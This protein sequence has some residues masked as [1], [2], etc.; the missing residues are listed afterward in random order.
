[1][2]AKRLIG[3]AALGA[4]VLG[5]WHVVRPW[6]QRW[7]ASDAELARWYPGDELLPPSGPAVTHAVTVDAP[8]ERIWPWLAQI[9]QHHGGFYS[10]TW[11]ENLFGCRMRNAERIVPEWQ[12]VRF[13]DPVWLHPQAPPM[14]VA[15][16]SANE[17]LV[18]AATFPPEAAPA[19]G[20]VY[21]IWG[22]HLAPLPGGRTRM[23][24]RQRSDPSRGMFGA[25][26]RLPETVVNSLFWEPAHFIME[27]R[28]LLHIKAL[29]EREPA[30]TAVETLPPRSQSPSSTRSA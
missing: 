15:V 20:S 2:N 23:I 28:M 21:A 11:L 8:P 30:S 13:N 9:G 17:A 3:P 1:M 6:H 24:A 4:A 10:Y 26:L 7:G 27:R 19:P 29:A 12:Q 14:R 18:L 25:P 16:A 22:L 5:Y